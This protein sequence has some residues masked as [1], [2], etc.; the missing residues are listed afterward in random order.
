MEFDWTEFING[1]IVKNFDFKPVW[2]RVVWFVGLDSLKQQTSAW[3]K[4]KFYYKEP[5]FYESLQENHHTILSIYCVP[6][7]YV[8]V[9]LYFACMH[10]GQTEAQHNRRHTHLKCPPKLKYSDIVWTIMHSFGVTVTRCNVVI[11]YLIP[12]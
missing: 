9:W 10:T 7:Q 11:S 4:L 5:C 2:L 6:G 3:M 12:S 1:H 8:Y